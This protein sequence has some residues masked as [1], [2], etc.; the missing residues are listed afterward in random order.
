MK[1]ILKSEVDNLGLPGDVVDVADGY[2]RNY[3][4][5]RGMAIIATRGAMKE[6]EALTR[7]RKVTEAKTLGAAE[8]AREALEARTLRLTARVDERGNLYG[9][10]SASDIQRVL[11]ERGHDVPRKRIELKGTIK[12]IGTY[13]VPVRVHSQVTAT[14]TVEVVDVEG[15]VTGQGAVDDTAVDDT[16]V[17]AEKAL[18]AAAE[19]E[20]D[21]T[22]EQATEGETQDAN[23]AD[24]VDEAQPA[25]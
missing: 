22:A 12:E 18:E 21:E 9:S 1:V 7:S 6:A 23:V 15:K 16:E 17:L 3:L 8:A 20:G 19:F 4:I 14:V 11:R 25:Q 10:V 24:T 13:D 2:G 5:P